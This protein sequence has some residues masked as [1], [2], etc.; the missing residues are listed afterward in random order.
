MEVRLN[1]EW[2]NI[3][4]DNYYSEYEADVICH[5]LGYTGASS[6]DSAGFLR[7]SATIRFNGYT[8]V[9]FSYGA[10]KKPIILDN[11]NCGRRDYLT[12]LQCSFVTTS[13]NQRCINSDFYDAT[14]SCC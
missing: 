6:Y 9:L 10:D 8:F 2:G 3:C 1:R 5:Q 14:V 13:V 7:Y 4:N 11:V 12:I